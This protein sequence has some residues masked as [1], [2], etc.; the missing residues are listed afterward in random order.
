MFKN[1][2]NKIKEKYNS[3]EEYLINRYP[4]NYFD[5]YIDIGTRGVNHPWHI[6]NIAKNN[7]KTIFGDFFEKLG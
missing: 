4:K 5:Y 2:E 6:N 7:P 3:E 1:I